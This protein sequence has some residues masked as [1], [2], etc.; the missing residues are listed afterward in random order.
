MPIDAIRNRNSYHRRGDKTTPRNII[1]D[2]QQVQESRNNKLY[3]PMIIN[4]DNKVRRIL[5]NNKHDR[6]REVRERFRQDRV[7][8]GRERFSE[9]Q[10]FN[11]YK[12]QLE[13]EAR[14]LE[15][16]IDNLI[17]EEISIEFDKLRQID[18]EKS[19]V[20]DDEEMKDNGNDD[21][22]QD[23]LEDYLKSEEEEILRQQEELEAAMNSL[24]CQD[25]N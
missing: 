12:L 20:I 8:L 7:T 21:Q 15:L 9:L 17:D 14:Q 4:Q 1:E 11:D 25:N 22:Y 10:D 5:I 23:E 13:N 19:K 24:T 6:L 18:Q 16:N 2:V 3:H